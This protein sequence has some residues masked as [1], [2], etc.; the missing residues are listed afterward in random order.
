MTNV[1]RL[2]MSTATFDD[3]WREYPLKKGKADAR[4]LFNLITRPG[5]FDTVKALK[6]GGEVVSKVPVHL[7]A[8]PEQLVEGAR[9]FARSL[10]NRQTW[11]VDLAYCPHAT[12]WLHHE[13]WDDE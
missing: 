4:T 2:Q 12:T 1:T 8:T 13:R 9:Q 3:F 6:D 10:V 5:G 11:T 7:E